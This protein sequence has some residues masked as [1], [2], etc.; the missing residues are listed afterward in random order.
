MTIPDDA[1]LLTQEEQLAKLDGLFGHYENKGK[2]FDPT[3]RFYNLLTTEEG[4]LLAAKQLHH[5]LGIKPHHLHVQFS[6]STKP[7]TSATIVIPAGYANQ[8]YETGA[9]LAQAVLNQILVHRKH[10]QPDDLFLEF[11]TIEC[12]LGIVILNG[13]NRPRHTLFQKLGFQKNIGKPLQLSALTVSDYASGLIEYATLYETDLTKHVTFM[14]AATQTIL[15]P[16]LKYQTSHIPLPDAVR[17][18]RHAL[19]H[20][21]LKAVLFIALAILPVML[22]LFV[23]S[24]RP[25]KPSTKV[26]TQYQKVLQLK[27]QYDNCIDQAQKQ[28]N[29]Y[30]HTD[31]FMERQ[32]DAT[33]VRCASLRNQYHYEIDQYNKMVNED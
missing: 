29:T 16:V 15:A 20:L 30:D 10:Y 22:G 18:E 26:I 4:L 23:W 8:P 21:Q 5:W 9:L 17:Q 19:R 24:Q 31:I 25:Y 11:A 27:D 7:V 33:L 32:V 13:L 28:R 1:V 3:T 12:G 2:F 6:N 14:T